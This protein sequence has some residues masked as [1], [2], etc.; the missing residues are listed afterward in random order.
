MFSFGALTAATVG[1]LSGSQ[2]LALTNASAGNVLLTIGNNNVTSTYTGTLSGGGSL[3]KRGAGTITL[4]SG[5]SGGA[6]YTGTTA[7]NN[8]TLVIGGISNLTGAID[9]TGDAG[10][11]NLV[12]QDSA[13]ITTSTIQIDTGHGNADAAATNSA[14]ASTMVVK[15]NAHVT[16]NSLT[17]G[18][19]ATRV[20]AGTFFTVQDSAIVNISGAL[21]LLNDLGGTTVGG[22]TVLSTVNLNGGT[23]AVGN[24]ATPT[25][26]N[27][28]Q[29]SAFNFSGGLLTALASDGAAV[30]FPSSTQVT[31]T[32]NAGGAP[33]NTNGFNITIAQNLVAGTT[34]VSSGTDGGLTKTGAGTLIVSGTNTYTGP[35]TINAGTLQFGQEVSLYDDNQASWTPS[36]IIVNPTTTAAFNVGGGGEF[37]DIRHRYLVGNAQHRHD[38]VY[39]TARRSVWIP[40]TLAETTTSTAQSAIPMEI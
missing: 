4:G 26:G 40:R 19:G 31:T 21:S 36:N 22:N 23:L 34:N 1:G 37:T 10:T 5:A 38:R 33:I 32:V 13:I 25:G 8:G 27:G 14:S 28:T 35:S 18:S 12:V 7:V 17:L 6:A 39:Q 16:A 15:N 30:F 2:S 20:L 9:L 11:S 24:I 3:I 29:R